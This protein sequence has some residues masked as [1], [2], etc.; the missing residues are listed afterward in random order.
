MGV[1]K[2]ILVGPVVSRNGG[3][4][5][6]TFCTPN[7]LKRGYPYRR[8]EQA[9]YDR[10][11]TLLGLQLSHDFVT[12]ACETIFEFQQGCIAPQV[13]GTAGQ[14]VPRDMAPDDAFAFQI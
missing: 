4:A 9:N 1:L 3:F 14:K 6:D 8:V 7:G 5:F 11:A 10:K 12:T 13:D 2:Q